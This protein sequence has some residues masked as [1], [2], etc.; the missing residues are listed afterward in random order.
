MFFN[1]SPSSSSM[2]YFSEQ[3]C[4]SNKKPKRAQSDAK[5]PCPFKAVQDVFPRPA[6]LIGVYF[7]CCGK[8][9]S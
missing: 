6:A 3:G 7:N 9:E 8:A 1:G 2:P 5:I 4:E